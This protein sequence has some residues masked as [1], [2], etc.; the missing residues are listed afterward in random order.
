MR[1]E[2]I[3]TALTSNESPVC[4]LT[5]VS[6]FYLSQDGTKV[7]ALENISCRVE[8]G[9]FVSVLGPSGCGK[10]TLLMIIAGLIQPSQGRVIVQDKDLRDALPD[11]G[12]VFQDAVL[13]PWRTAL[14]NVELPGEIVGETRAQRR[15]AAQELLQLVGLAGFERKFPNELSGGM[16]QRVAIA[17]ALMRSPSLLL[18]DEPFGALDAMTREQLNL[19]LQQISLQSKSTIIFVTHSIAEAAFLSDRV[20]VMSGRPGTIKDTIAIDIPRPRPIEL[21]TSDR[22][23]TWVQHLR[24]ALDHSEVGA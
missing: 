15:G 16:Q 17:R 1:S 23:G 20:I 13:F 10:S 3:S 6:K 11:I 21:I 22:F 19:E 2:S 12:I 24:H 18:M 14:Q 8:P 9:Q 5:E 4:E 7:I